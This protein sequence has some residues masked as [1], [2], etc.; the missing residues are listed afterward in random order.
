[1]LAC[2]P[3]AAVWLRVQQDLGLAPRTVEAYGRALTDY[4]TVCQRE[5]IAPVTATRSD[6]ARYVRDLTQRPNPR[7]GNVL[8]IDS[9]VGL[10][11]ATLQQRL[12][13]VRLFYDHLIEE[14]QRETNPVGRGR[15]T[16]GRAF[17]GQRERGLIPRFTKLPWI[18]TDAQWTH[19]LEQA[20][21]ESIRNRLMLA[22]AY[23]AA[24]RREELCAL[25]TDDLDPARR[26][27]RI[28]AET[29]KNRLERIVPYSAATGA[30]LASYLRER[31]TRSTA[32]GPLLLSESHRNDAAPLTLWTWSKVVRALAVRAELPRLGTHTMRHLRLTDLA[33]AGWE[34][35]A[36][37]Q[38]AG[39]RSPA[40]TLQYI[41]LSGRDLALKLA[42]G[43][44]QLHAQR[45][46]LLAA[47]G[48][49]GDGQAETHAATTS[50]TAQE[51]AP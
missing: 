50:G 29:T 22:L 27:L 47:T 24:L 49:A 20:K 9:G 25:R 28:R 1:V 21:A 26:T 51:S 38:F 23:D 18:P 40:T 44:E 6:I 34:L 41:H 10:A 14:G 12:T 3:E 32:R 37:A 45:L 46:Q 2:C 39:H 48:D 19:L 17:G 8:V 43:M 16:P 13:A 33:R 42:R 31:R 7:G 11:N 5:G 15:Y 36:I 30:V 35:H 4:L